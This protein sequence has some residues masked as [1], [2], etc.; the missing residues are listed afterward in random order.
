MAN[1]LEF[2]TVRR[3]VGDLIPHDH[4][5]RTLNEKQ[6]Q[7]LM[8]S[9]RKFSLVEIPA[10]NLNNKIIAGHQRI[11]ILSETMGRDYEIEV[12]IP[13]RLLTDKEY[14]EYLIRSNNNGGQNDNDI[15]DAYF[16]CDDLIDWGLDDDYFD[17][18]SDDIDSAIEESTQETIES[19]KITLVYDDDDLLL[20]DS[21]ILKLGD[22]Y[23]KTNTSRIVIKA[24]QHACLSSKA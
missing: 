3:K 23:K 12:R 4:N 7:T 11:K 15:L 9:L 22:K 5:P 18:L 21:L 20:F 14:Q 1:D 16:D 6:K 10:I 13:N 2:T 19:G 24:L 8:E 17:D